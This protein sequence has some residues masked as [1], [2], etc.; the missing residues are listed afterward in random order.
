M[1]Y[2]AIVGSR[3]RTDRERVS[4]LVAKL[5]MCYGYLTIVSGGCE[6]PDTWAAE[7][8]WK[9]GIPVIEHRPVLCRESMPAWAYTRAYYKRNALIAQECDEMFA[10]VALDRKGGTENAIRC[11]I[12]LN[13]RV[14]II[15]PDGTR[16]TIEPKP[17]QASLPI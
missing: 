16:Q 8:A 9:L 10:F 4:M 15:L 5:H 7:I 12:K 17:A 3:R 1:Y 11:A 6:G 13:K 2:V 14:T